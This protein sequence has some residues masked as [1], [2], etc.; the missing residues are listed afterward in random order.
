MLVY[1]LNFTSNNLF[2][3]FTYLP[4]QAVSVK[5]S[6]VSQPHTLLNH[7][8]LSTHTHTLHTLPILTLF[9]LNLTRL[10]VQTLRPKPVCSFQHLAKND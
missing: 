4:V 5:G 1:S 10:H 2:Y 7:F 6:P 3:I 9:M 8:Y